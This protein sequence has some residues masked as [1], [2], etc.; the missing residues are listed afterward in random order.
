MD[1]DVSTL[2]SDAERALLAKELRGDTV[3]YMIKAENLHLF[4]PFI[5]W[6]DGKWNTLDGTSDKDFGG[7]CKRMSVGGQY[8]D[9]LNLKALALVRNVSI[10][11]FHYNTGSDDIRITRHV[12][13]HVKGPKMRRSP[14][15]PR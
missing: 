7:Y 3:G 9:E 12:K 1:R 8:G 6:H 10:Q 15:L 2:I 4:E 13:T 11:V 5:G 14:M